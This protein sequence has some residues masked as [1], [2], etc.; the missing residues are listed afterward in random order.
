[1]PKPGFRSFI[2][3]TKVDSA[4][5]HRGTAIKQATKMI[6]ME[7]EQARLYRLE[8]VA[9]DSHVFL[10]E[11]TFTHQALRCCDEYCS[12]FLRANPVAVGILADAQFMEGFHIY[13][14]LSS[15]CVAN[16]VGQLIGA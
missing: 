4:G 1:M 5:F 12:Q 6:S 3:D 8:A 10:S 11:S 14:G 15:P 2:K 13:L 16:F 9:R 7:V